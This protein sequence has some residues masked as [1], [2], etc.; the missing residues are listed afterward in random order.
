MPQTIDGVGEVVVFG[1]RS[2][3]IKLLIDPDRL[4]HYSKGRGVLSFLVDGYPFA[5]EI[6][7]AQAPF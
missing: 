4:R 3:Q 1:G 6:Q 7:F 5:E 2:K